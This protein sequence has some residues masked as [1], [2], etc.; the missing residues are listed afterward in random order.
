MDFIHSYQQLKV[1]PR[2][3]LGEP[4][5]RNG[6][7]FT[8]SPLRYIV[9]NLVVCARLNPVIF[10]TY[11]RTNPRLFRFNPSYPCCRSVWSTQSYFSSLFRPLNPSSLLDSKNARISSRLIRPVLCTLMINSQ[12]AVSPFQAHLL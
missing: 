12:H 8:L 1:R 9:I 10:S 6:S 3:P 11:R 2:V 7:A 5:S 4:V